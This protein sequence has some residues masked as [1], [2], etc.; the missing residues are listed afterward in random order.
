MFYILYFVVVGFNKEVFV[1][2]NNDTCWD[3]DRLSLKFFKAW[4]NNYTFHNSLQHR[5]ILFLFYLYSFCKAQ[6]SYNLGQPWT[7]ASSLNLFLIKRGAAVRC[8]FWYLSLCDESSQSTGVFLWGLSLFNVL[9][10]Y[11]L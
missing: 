6:I 4:S 8:I 11:L 10:T 9:I 1:S 5:K 3:W 2:D 7:S